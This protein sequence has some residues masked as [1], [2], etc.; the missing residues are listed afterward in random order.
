MILSRLNILGGALLAV[1]MTTLCGCLPYGKQSAELPADDRNPPVA[2]GGGGD[3]QPA[4][5]QDPV[6]TGQQFFQLEMFELA[7]PVGSI[8]T[9]DAF[10]KPFDETF[11][12]LWKHDVLRK[13]GLRVGRAPL[14]ELALLTEQLADA[15]TK[16][17]SLIGIRGRDF[18]MAMK[19]NVDRQNIFYFDRD[20]KLSGNSYE[21][22]D[23]IFALSFRQTPRTSDHVRL[24]IAP[25]VRESQERL[26]RGAGESPKFARPQTFFDLG[27]ELDLGADECLIISAA[28]LSSQ[29]RLVVGRAFMIEERPSQMVEKALVIIPR[30]RG[31]LQE[32]L[33]PP[34]VQR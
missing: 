10:W 11:L 26:V 5:P 34:K 29:N 3:Y 30:L 33:T 9:N 8:S 32:V 12:G 28:D 19:S 27:L 23:N 22:A 13:N 2:D 31:E 25:A 15:E 7:V 4:K 16:E 1:V 21:P 6:K 24:A 20:G 18:E 14:T 17:S